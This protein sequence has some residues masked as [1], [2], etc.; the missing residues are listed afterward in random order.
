LPLALPI[1]SGWKEGPLRRMDEQAAFY[2]DENS[3]EL[4]FE[5]TPI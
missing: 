1:P 5:T 2:S 4:W 3:E